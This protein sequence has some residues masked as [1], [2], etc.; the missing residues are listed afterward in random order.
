MVRGIREC[1]ST[2]ASVRDDNESFE[3]RC[4]RYGCDIR[5]PCFNS[6]VAIARGLGS[7]VPRKI[8]RNGAFPGS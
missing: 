1:H 2:A 8:E 3:L 5:C 4:I 7:A 6:V